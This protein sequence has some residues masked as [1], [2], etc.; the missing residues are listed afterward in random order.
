[1]LLLLGG[2]LLLLTACQ[3]EDDFVTPSK[4]AASSQSSDAKKSVDVKITLTLVTETPNGWTGPF[5][6]RD[7]FKAHGDFIMVVTPTTDDS[8]HCVQTLIADHGTMTI[9]SN[10]SFATGTGRWHVVTSSGVFKDMDGRGSLT[11]P[12]DKEGHPLEVL[13]G[14]MTMN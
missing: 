4:S 9:I 14:K 2:S 11:M 1:M 5:K 12:M 10:C 8:I 3:K 13:V 6:I 7:G